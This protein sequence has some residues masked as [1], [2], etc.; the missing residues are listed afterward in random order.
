MVGVGHCVVA[1][2][3]GHR[4]L[5]NCAIL[6]LTS[7]EFR[8]KARRP[9]PGMKALILRKGPVKTDRQRFA[10]EVGVI[11]HSKVGNDPVLLDQQVPHRIR[12]RTVIHDNQPVYDAEQQSEVGFRTTR[13]NQVWGNVGDSAWLILCKQKSDV[14]SDQFGLLIEDCRGNLAGVRRSAPAQ[15][16]ERPDVVGGHVGSAT[17][18]RPEGRHVVTAKIVVGK[19][20][21]GQ[22]GVVHLKGLEQLLLGTAKVPIGLILQP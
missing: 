2:R 18:P 3:E 6:R 1:G 5:S 11:G 10:L 8:F 22:I 13:A 7:R 9:R 15:L 12:R 21:T 19:A 20:P 17:G 14:L 4:L 16:E